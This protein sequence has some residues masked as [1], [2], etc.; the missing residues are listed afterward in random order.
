MAERK[1][2]FR[3]REFYD[4]PRVILLATSL[5]VLEMESLF[6]EEND[7]YNDSYTVTVNGAVRD[8]LATGWTNVEGGTGSTIGRIPVRD[9]K[10][11]RTKRSYFVSPAFDDMLSTAGIR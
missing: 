1:C 4:V 8:D 6:D 5:F 9:L 2:H 3:Y 11:D 10:F 7:D